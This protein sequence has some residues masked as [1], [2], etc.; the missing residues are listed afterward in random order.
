MQAYAP[1]ILSLPLTPTMSRRWLSLVLQ[2]LRSFVLLTLWS[3]GVSSL[4]ACL[5]TGQPG[6]LLAAALTLALF[7]VFDFW[8]CLLAFSGWIALFPP[9]S[10][11]AWAAL[12]VCAFAAGLAASWHFQTER[13][14][15]VY[16]EEDGS[17]PGWE[18]VHMISLTTTISCVSAIV[19]VWRSGLQARTFTIAPGRLVAIPTKPGT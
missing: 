17:M 2:C 18:P 10:P 19:S 7:T 13:P 12:L 16:H 1:T 11:G 6:A 8:P 5:A 14:W 4:L 3:V 15:D 9:R